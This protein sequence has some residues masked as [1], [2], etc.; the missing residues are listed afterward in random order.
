MVCRTVTFDQ[1]KAT[2]WAPLTETEDDSIGTQSS[3]EECYLFQHGRDLERHVSTVIRGPKL[4]T[5]AV[6]VPFL[7]RRIEATETAR[8]SARLQGS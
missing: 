1:R 5:S 3:V 6:A 7:E 8:Q 2:T 4:K